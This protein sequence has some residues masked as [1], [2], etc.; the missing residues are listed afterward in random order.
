[1]PL[2]IY[3]NIKKMIK[4]QFINKNEHNRYLKK[5]NTFLDLCIY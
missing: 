4:F 3:V 5:I 1:M 2:K